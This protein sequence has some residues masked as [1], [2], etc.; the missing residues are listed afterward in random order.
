MIE[1]CFELAPLHN[2]PN[3][4][5]IKACEEVFPGIPQVG[6]FD[7]AFHSTLPPRAYLYAFPFELYQNDRVRRYGFHGTSHKYVSHEAARYLNQDIGQLEDH[8][9]S[10]GQWKQHRRG[11]GGAVY[12][13]QYG[14]HSSRRADHGHT[15]R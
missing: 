3:L 4:E 13:H 8:H 9:L 15:L 10:P 1:E 5:G 14:V 6:V 2:P 11:E 12:R 7:T